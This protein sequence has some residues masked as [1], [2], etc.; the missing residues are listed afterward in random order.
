V[1]EYKPNE[2]KYHHRSIVPAK[3]KA[4]MKIGREKKQANRLSD[5]RKKKG[6]RARHHKFIIPY[7]KKTGRPCIVLIDC[8]GSSLL[9]AFHNNVRIRDKIE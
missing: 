3:T 9:V 4:E 6:G 1:V 7:C 5:Q 2:G 8:P